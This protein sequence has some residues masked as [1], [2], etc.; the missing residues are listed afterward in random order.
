MIFVISIILMITLQLFV[1]KTK[2]GCAMRAVSADTDAARL[3][4]INVD[5]TISVTFALGS[6]LAGAAGI[7][8]GIYYNTINPLMGSTPGTKAFIA[9]VFGGIGSI[10]GAMIGGFVIAFI[11]TM[12]GGY[13][14]TLIQDAVVYALLIIILIFKPR[15][16][17]GIN[18][19]EKV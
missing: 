3:M 9:A 12:V 4:G 17:M 14:S 8:V 2:T 6:A 11:E 19:R 1:T 7:M 15:G 5:R 18:R 13:V 10:P 16:L